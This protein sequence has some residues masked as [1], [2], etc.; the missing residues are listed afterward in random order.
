MR[1]M[2]SMVL[3]VIVAST[4]TGI[5]R[6]GEN[7]ASP[8]PAVPSALREIDEL[9]RLQDEAAA[10]SYAAASRQK[11]LLPSIGRDLSAAPGTAG[12]QLAAAAAIHVLSGGD[13][14]AAE[15]LS[16]IE[17]LSSQDRRLL[18]GVSHFMRGERE[19]AVT[20]IGSLEVGSLPNRLAGRVAMAQGLLA[21][22]DA[23]AE[24]FAFA[25]A[26]MPG[27]LIEE[28]A[29]RRSALA[30][31]AA[32]D[33]STFMRQL[34]R[35]VRRFPD[36]VYGPIFWR[37]LMAAVAT[38]PGKLSPIDLAQLDSVIAPL[39]QNTRRLIYRN[40]ARS[41]AAAG[42]P[43]LASLAGKRLARLAPEGGIEHDIGVF[44]ASLYGIVSPDGDAAITNLASTPRDALDLQ[45]RALLDAA[46]T[47]ARQITRPPPLPAVA[48]GEPVEKSGI[49][50]RGSALLKESDRVLS[51]IN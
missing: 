31:A 47:L 36:S 32:Q 50:R 9:L 43:E 38:R 48:S 45:E 6:A 46:L 17:S 28:S 16:K 35:Y 13:P 39:R 10:G 44:Y 5:S 14:A 23:R 15:A 19:A 40:L 29:L 26:A 27:T 8:A 24:R 34:E 11:E 2:A 33:Q 49:E 18:E 22:D 42:H 41:A 1:V 25:I 20:L 21:K 51:E 3:I 4:A 37:D 7:N 30:L 12:P